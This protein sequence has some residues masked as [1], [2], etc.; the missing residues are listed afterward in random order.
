MVVMEIRKIVIIVVFMIIC[1]CSV[2]KSKPV[3]GGV[4]VSNQLMKNREASNDS[5]Y[6]ILALRIDTI[7]NNTLFVK[8][9]FGTKN[10]DVNFEYKTSCNC[11]KSIDDILF[12]PNGTE[13]EKIYLKFENPKEITFYFVKGGKNQTYYY[14]M[15]Y[16]D[17]VNLKTHR[18]VYYAEDGF[19][20]FDE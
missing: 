11:Y 3:N 2:N 16:V 6:P 18:D 20:L 5:I 7:I 9:R 10:M 12:T 14:S 17:K 8:Y 4:Y 19:K 13:R 1:A 15:T